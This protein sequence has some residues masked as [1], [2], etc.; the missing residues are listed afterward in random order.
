MFGHSAIRARRATR[1]LVAVALVGSAL[2]VPAGVAGAEAFHTSNTTATT[3]LRACTDTRQGSCKGW[4][5]IAKGNT[6]SMIC[7]RKQGSA[8]DPLN[9]GTNMYFW[10]KGKTG[11]NNGG[12]TVQG[13]VSANHVTNQWKSSPYCDNW[14]PFRAARWAGEKL[15][16]SSYQL[17]CY[18]F[19]RDAYLNG[20]G[21]NIGSVGTNNGPTTYWASYPHNLIGANFI[22]TRYK[23]AFAAGDSSTWDAPVGALVVWTDSDV[24]HIAISI[25]AG[26]VIST[27]FG[28]NSKIHIFRITQ[29]PNNYL[30][31]VQYPN[32]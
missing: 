5:S 22:G 9:Y 28:G 32:S 7:W 31:W 20:A 18:P 14:L 15:G 11:A 24:G 19:V 12:G 30:G 8:T 21:K 27:R 2:L 23:K 26:Y 16:E 1:I 10:V 29:F 4:T 25:G 13:Y 6:V 17:L 3:P